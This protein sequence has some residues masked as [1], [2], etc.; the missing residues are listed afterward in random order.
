V[1]TAA[2]EEIDRTKAFFR[3]RLADAEKTAEAHFQQELDEMTQLLLDQVAAQK[4]VKEQH[5]RRMNEMRAEQ[6]AVVQMIVAEQSLEKQSLE[7][8]IARLQRTI[9]VD[10][11]GA[12][13]HAET[14]IAEL[15]A[16]RAALVTA[17]ADA[18]RLNGELVAAMGQQAERY[19]AEG[20][21]LRQALAEANATAE[22]LQGAVARSEA[23]ARAALQTVTRPPSPS[24]RTAHILLSAD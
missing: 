13:A 12:R 5:Q 6:D 23:E 8:E 15:R 20:R 3:E 16:E 24:L 10:H 4:Q 22:R 9:H 19:G 2:R 21:D 18:A 14:T 1:L 17:N 11:A 7:A